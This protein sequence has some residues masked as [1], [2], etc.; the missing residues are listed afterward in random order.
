[1]AP[2]EAAKMKKIVGF[3]LIYIKLNNIWIQQVNAPS[4][5]LLLIRRWKSF[6]HETYSAAQV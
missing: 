2:V 1:M 3:Q 4:M 5:Y 6:W